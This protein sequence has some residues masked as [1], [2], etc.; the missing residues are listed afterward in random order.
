MTT[1]LIL[2]DIQNDFYTGGALA[3]PGCEAVVPLANSLMSAYIR[4][5]CQLRCQ[6]CGDGVS[7]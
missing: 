1:A 5:M 6:K 3:V 2:V 4:R 7:G